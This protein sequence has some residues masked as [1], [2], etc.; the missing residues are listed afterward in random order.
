MA[1]QAPPQVPFCLISCV[2]YMN[3]HW[4]AAL[5]TTQQDFARLVAL[6]Q[7]FATACNALS[8]QAQATR[9]WNRVALH[10]M[11]YKPLREAYP[12]LGSQMI[13]NV[14]YSVSRAC[15]AVY[16]GRNSP[17]NVQV[18]GERPLPR[19]I[20]DADAPVYFDKHT[21][22]IRNSQVSLF[23]TEG[24]IRFDIDI[25]LEQ[26]QRIRQDRVREI[27]LFRKP[28]GF[29]LDF[30]FGELADDQAL[31]TA[32]PRNDLPVPTF[33]TVREQAARPA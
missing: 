16:Q 26:E 1:Q 20:F 33:I 32:G 14:I 30:A 28:D 27:A 24:R 13:C 7:T 21:L 12:Q 4:R 10:H 5:P 11:A 8:A 29:V 22:S 3:T 25:S 18:W 23:T 2:S 15:R 19:V 31:R 6:Q 9:C 17:F